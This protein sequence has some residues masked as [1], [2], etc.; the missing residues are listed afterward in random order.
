MQTFVPYKGNSYKWS[1]PTLI[2]LTIATLWAA[3]AFVFFAHEYAHAFTAWALGWKRN[4][5]ALN[6]AHPTLTVLL[7]Q[8][9][10]SQNVDEAPI[11]A[12]R[13][14]YQAALISAA[15]A[16]LGNALVTYTLSRWLYRFAQRHAARGWA[17]LAYWM[18]V[19]SIGNFIDYVPVRTFIIGTD[20][21]Q[22]MFA[23]ERGFGWS[24]WTLLFVFGIP[25]ILA[26]GYFFLRIQPETL[27][28]FFPRWRAQRVFVAVVTSFFLFAFYSAAGWADGGLI[29]HRMSVASVCIVAATMAVLTAFLSTTGGCHSYFGKDSV[30]Q[31]RN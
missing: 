11:F 30:M 5:L 13:H 24:P 22:D 21:D 12:S 28:W 23:V 4:P 15:G 27:T 10:I 16:V 20:L 25:T 17:M 31:S 3:H 1:L 7:V 8:L 9:G 18:T 29:A 14:G 6:Y 2:G 19:A 26:V